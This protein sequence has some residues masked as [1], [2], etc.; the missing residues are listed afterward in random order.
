MR[1]YTFEQKITYTELSLR[2]DIILRNILQHS[3]GGKSKIYNMIAQKIPHEQ[4]EGLKGAGAI[5]GLPTPQG[6]LNSW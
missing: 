4:Q 1:C 3:E 6:K 5:A 2:C